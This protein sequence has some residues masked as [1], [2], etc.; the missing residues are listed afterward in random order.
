MPYESDEDRLA[1]LE[2]RVTATLEVIESRVALYADKLELVASTLKEVVA[3]LEAHGRAV[4]IDSLKLARAI[5]ALTPFQSGAER[6]RLL[7]EQSKRIA[8][9]QAEFNAALPQQKRPQDHPFLDDLLPPLPPRG[10][11]AG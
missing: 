10:P 2:S 8:E 4:Q 1:R 6:E 3:G 5:T 7:D 9:L 11:A